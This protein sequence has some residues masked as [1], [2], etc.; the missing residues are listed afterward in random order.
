MARLRIR[1]GSLPPRV[2]CENFFEDRLIFGMQPNSVP[3][4]GRLLTRND[5]L[6]GVINVAVTEILKEFD[7][8]PHP[9]DK[10]VVTYDREEAMPA[11]SAPDP[12]VTPEMVELEKWASCRDK[13][14]I[15][16][17]EFQFKKKQLL[18]RTR[19]SDGNVQTMIPCDYCGTI[20]DTDNAKCPSCGAPFKR[21]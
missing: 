14:I 17:E 4:I 16:E 7:L 21:S 20:Y 15:T 12:G 11:A 6:G 10:A 1:A 3:D 18:Y 5:I 13:G 8:I 2:N 19:D 9:P